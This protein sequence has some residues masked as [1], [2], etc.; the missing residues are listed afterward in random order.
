M[1]VKA[2]DVWNWD[3][4]KETVQR[5]YTGKQMSGEGRLSLIS[6]KVLFYD[7]LVGVV[8]SR[9]MTKMA[10]T[11]FDPPLSNPLL[12]ANFTALSS[13]KPEIIADFYLV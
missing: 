9:H 12:Y 2:A 8:T 1:V 6:L 7:D 13:I 5:N 4:P 10:V 11:P 3:S